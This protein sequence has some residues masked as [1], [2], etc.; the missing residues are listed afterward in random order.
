[1]TSPVSHWKPMCTELYHLHKGLKAADVFQAQC[2]FCGPD[3]ML[4]L[5]ATAMQV[6][7]GW[8]F[9]TDG[10]PGFRLMNIWSSRRET[11]VTGETSQNGNKCEKEVNF[12]KLRQRRFD[13]CWSALFCHPE[14]VNV[15]TL[16]A[17]GAWTNICSAFF[18]SIIARLVY[19][20]E[21]F[22]LIPLGLQ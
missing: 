6:L 22:A 13:S 4:S 19:I 1:M 8:N 21:S 3:Q 12:L 5:S 18:L 2:V 7:K 10:T 16:R 15:P 20:T 17:T 9:T 11:P 14:P